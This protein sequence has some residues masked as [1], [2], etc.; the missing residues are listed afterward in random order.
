MCQFISLL[1]VYLLCVYLLVGVILNQSASKIHAIL[2]K[3]QHIW[4]IV[5]CG[6][7]THSAKETRQ[8]ETRVEA[9]VEELEKNWKERVGNMEG[10]S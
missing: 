10:S 9:G 7:I 8:Q 5:A 3:L 2:S 6:M 1:S 4:R